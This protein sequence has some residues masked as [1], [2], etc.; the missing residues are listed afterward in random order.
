MTTVHSAPTT[1]RGGQWPREE[2]PPNLSLL[3]EPNDEESVQASTG[4]LAEYGHALQEVTPTDL[5][6]FQIDPAPCVR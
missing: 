3:V 1:R 5:I 2:A 6:F 4:A